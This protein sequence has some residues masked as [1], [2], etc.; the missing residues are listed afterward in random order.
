VSK[1]SFRR[2]AVVTGAALAVGSMAPALAAQVGANGTTSASVGV[3]NVTNGLPSVSS[4][5]PTALITSVAGTAVGTVQSTPGMALAD[6]NNLMSG[7]LGITGGLTNGGSLPGVDV[8]ANT[9]D[10][11]LGASVAVNGVPSASGLVSGVSAIPG[12]LVGTAL[13]TATPLV[14][15]AV[16]L[17]NTGVGL[18]GAVPGIALGTA[19]GL[20]NSGLGI[21]NGS[22]PSGNVN[23]LAGLMGSL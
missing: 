22:S 11:A 7:I 20:L 15:T 14:G 17:A 8:A 6:V 4:L 21:I 19:G 10:G 2:L 5:V 12:T 3:P 13:S 16:G 23:V 18:A 9:S 1:R